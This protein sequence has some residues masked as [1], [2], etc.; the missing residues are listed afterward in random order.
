MKHLAEYNYY[1]PFE[2]VYKDISGISWMKFDD[3]GVVMN[4]KKRL[5]K[6]YKISKNDLYEADR[7][8]F[9]YHPA[10]V[11]QCALAT[12]NLMTKE[13][14]VKPFRDT[15]VSN[16]A[17]IMENGI[18]YDNSTVYP[19]PF[20]LPD[21]HPNPG[22]VS[23]MYQGLVLSALVRAYLIS[24]NEKIYSSCERVWNSYSADLG[25]KY[26]FRYETDNELWF[27]EAPQLPAKHILNGEIYAIWGIYDFMIINDNPGLKDQ[28]RKSVS[29]LVNHLSRYD[30]GFWSYYDLAGNLASYYYHTKVH[31]IQL[32][33]LYEQTSEKMFKDYS[34][35]WASYSRS[36]R[37]SVLKK[38]Y[39]GYHLLN[40]KRHRYNRKIQEGNY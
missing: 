15:F 11:A 24:K 6:H 28:W 36:F 32:E 4:S 16:I 22:W 18:E 33:R 8:E 21:F 3:S 17:W 5:L 1:Y 19:F 37:S 23:G 29:T 2:N 40:R 14:H 34:A 25:E 10:A 39:S 26:G 9:Y 7:S 31:I 20:G 27:E 30:T 35:K 38:L 12:F 13:G